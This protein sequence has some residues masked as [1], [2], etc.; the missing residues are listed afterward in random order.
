MTAPLST[1]LAALP[2]IREG[3]RQ[4][5]RC[6]GR[7]TLSVTVA[8]QHSCGSSH[9]STQLLHTCRP[10][11]RLG[12]HLGESS[13]YKVPAGTSFRAPIAGPPPPPAAPRWRRLS[14][15]WLVE[16]LGAVSR[17]ATLHSP[18]ARLAR[19]A[20]A[21]VCAITPAHRSS[22]PAHTIGAG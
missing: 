2:I 1:L 3:E 17:S 7:K 20:L 14:C 5:W 4:H 6:I 16:T 18:S 19:V 22:G 8:M 13:P 9:S 12:C 10:A 15:S 11:E 21:E